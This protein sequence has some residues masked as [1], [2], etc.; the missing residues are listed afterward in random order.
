MLSQSHSRGVTPFRYSSSVRH[1]D[2]SRSF[3]SH[4][5]EKEVREARKEREYVSST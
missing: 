5:V 1:F 3:Q 2:R 4:K